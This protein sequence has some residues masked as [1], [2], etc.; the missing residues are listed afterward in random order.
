MYT[1]YLWTNIGPLFSR[2]GLSGCFHLSSIGLWCSRGF[3]LSRFEGTGVDFITHEP[4]HNSDGELLELEVCD[5]YLD[6][7]QGS[8][9]SHD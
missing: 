6:E 3:R 8:L 4:T 1:L 2:G 9:A 7:I 5:Q